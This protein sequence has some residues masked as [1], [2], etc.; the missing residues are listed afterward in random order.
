[1]GSVDG[2]CKEFGV[3]V[4]DA[5]TVGGDGGYEAVLAGGEVS[6]QF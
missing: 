6:Q 4:E 3:L 5:L 2:A 1:M